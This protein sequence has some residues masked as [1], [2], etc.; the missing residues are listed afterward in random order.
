MIGYWSSFARTG[1]P[2]ASHAP[3]WPPL[4]GPSG[5]T[6]ALGPHLRTVD[7]AVEHHCAFWSSL[8]G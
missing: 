2:V 7:L 3:A 4:T 1:V 6:I 5:P 8:R